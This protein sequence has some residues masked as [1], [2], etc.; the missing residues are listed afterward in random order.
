MRERDC[1]LELDFGANGVALLF[2][3]PYSNL[4]ALE[5]LFIEAKQLGVPA[6]R[7]ICTGDVVAYC[8]D[9]LRAVQRM[10]E[11][12]VTVLMGNCEEQLG[13]GADGCGC[14]FTPGMTCHVLSREW[15][16]FAASQLDEDSRA[17]MRTLPR[18]IRLHFAKR[19]L[20]VVHGGV[21][22]IN[23]FIFESSAWAEKESQIT[24]AGVEGI[25]AG[26]CGIPFTQIRDGHLWHNSG[27]IGMP[28]NDGQ[29]VTWYSLLHSEIGSIRIEHRQLRYPYGAAAE[30]MHH[31]G[32]SH[33][34]ADTLRSGL[35]PSLDIL[36]PQE[37]AQTGTPLPLADRVWHEARQHA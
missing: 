4:H 27:V 21:T 1:E 3:G 33:H 20:L 8:G 18:N 16:A 19:E 10:R 5:A 7:M 35:W 26:H 37:R 34:Y 22:Q 30:R 32:L 28:A 13:G 14:G 29:Q 25:L 36:P 12:G 17:W 6:S 31:V 23:Q 2:G 24:A 15:Y 11:S 9:P